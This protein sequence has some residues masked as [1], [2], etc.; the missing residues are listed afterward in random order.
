MRVSNQL[1]RR[2]LASTIPTYGASMQPFK[3]NAK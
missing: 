2:M 1:N 3:Y